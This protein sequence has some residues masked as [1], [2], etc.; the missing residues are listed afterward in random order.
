MSLFGRAQTNF[1][2]RDIFGIGILGSLGFVISTY[3]I[4]RRSI[5]VSKSVPIYILARE[6]QYNIQHILHIPLYRST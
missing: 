6:A 4:F 1:C 2:V 5:L 3:H